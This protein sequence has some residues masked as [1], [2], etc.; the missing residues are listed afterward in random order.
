M[1]E[2]EYLLSIEEFDQ[3]FF[4]ALYSF[5]DNNLYFRQTCFGKLKIAE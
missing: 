2:S 4:E 5:T 1:N 3:L